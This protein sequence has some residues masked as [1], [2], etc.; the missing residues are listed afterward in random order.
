MLFWLE[1]ELEAEYESLR[2]R[3]RREQVQFDLENAEDTV[4]EASAPLSLNMNDAKAL[5]LGWPMSM[6]QDVTSESVTDIPGCHVRF[7][8]VL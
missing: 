8:L 6:F 3:T 5:S 2:A 4:A 1:E 7:A